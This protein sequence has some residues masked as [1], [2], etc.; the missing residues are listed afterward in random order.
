M[1]QRDFILRQ[2]ELMMEVIKQVSGLASEKRFEA[3]L[4]VI[5]E[6]LESLFGLNSKLITQ[7]F[8]QGPLTQIAFGEEA[9]M[10]R[11]KL[12]AAATLLQDVGEIQV[13]QGAETESYQSFASA[14]EL[15][16]AVRLESTATSLPTYAPEVE[17]LVSQL[18][19]YHL[20]I[21]LNQL[22]FRFYH[23][24]SQLDEAEN[25][26][27]EMIEQEEETDQIVAQGISFYQAILAESDAFL[28]ASNLPREEAEESLAELVSLRDTPS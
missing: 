20:P 27:F 24:Q 23:Q 28:L 12:I 22:L 7:L 13:E 18:A 17:N 21:H 5:D 16:V 2:I 10:R 4:S 15:I 6:A 9:E 3:A 25:V 1:Y 8:G 14:L 11:A 26:L 19:S